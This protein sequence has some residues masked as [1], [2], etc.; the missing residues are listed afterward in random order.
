MSQIPEFLKELQK[1]DNDN[2]FEK[3][4]KKIIVYCNFIILLNILIY[5]IAALLFNII[6]YL[7]SI[8]INEE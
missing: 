6:F 3:A 2:P 1:Q 8:C 4:C 5:F 7:M